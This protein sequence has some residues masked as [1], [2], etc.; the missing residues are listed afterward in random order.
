MHFSSKVRSFSESP[1]KGSP[2]G[3]NAS[4][5]LKWCQLSRCIRSDAMCRSPDTGFSGFSATRHG[6][7][8]TLRL[9]SFSDKHQLRD[10][11]NESLVWLPFDLAAHTARTYLARLKA[12]VDPLGNIRSYLSVISL[13]SS[14][15]VPRH[16]NQ[17]KRPSPPIRH[18]AAT[19]S[20]NDSLASVPS[21]QGKEEQP[22][23]M[24]FCGWTGGRCREWRQ[25]GGV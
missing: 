21:R 12:W 25:R 18:V 11:G 24:P 9:C 1:C 20:R 2:I 13:P 4:L 15:C 23:T 22:S 7:F 10:L 17:S 5:D 19:R 14:Q 6:R 8:S 3:L 16:R